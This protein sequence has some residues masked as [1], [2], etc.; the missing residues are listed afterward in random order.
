MTRPTSNQKL[1]R[2]QGPAIPL[3]RRSTVDSR[4]LLTVAEVCAELDVARSTFFEWRAKKRAPR[5]IKLPNGGLRI[6]RVDLDRWLSMCED[7]RGAA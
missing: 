1:D 4:T 6:R 7:D 2:P 3:P 5:A